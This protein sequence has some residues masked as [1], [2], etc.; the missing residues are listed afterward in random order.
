MI[1]RKENSH[2]CISSHAESRAI[3]R[4]LNITSDVTRIIL[5]GIHAYEPFLK[6]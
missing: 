3:N 1:E 4:S 2:F 5:M 6:P